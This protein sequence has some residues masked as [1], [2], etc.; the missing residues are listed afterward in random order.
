M[1]RRKLLERAMGAAAVS[2]AFKFVDRPANAQPIQAGG[3]NKNSAPS[4]LKITDMR[5]IR[6]ASN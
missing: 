6:I 2:A 4:Q 3:V 1:T 5:A